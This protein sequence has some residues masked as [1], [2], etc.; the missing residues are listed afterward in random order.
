MMKVFGVELST[1]T[2]DNFRKSASRNLKSFMEVLRFMTHEHACFDNN[3]A[4]RDLRMNKVR[5]KVSG[6]FR[7]LQAGQGFMDFRPFIATT[8]K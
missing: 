1:G 4:E 5:Q 8:I 2:L 7:S 3:Q 6:G